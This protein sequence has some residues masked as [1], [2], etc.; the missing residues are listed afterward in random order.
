M[1][2]DLYVLRER[3]RIAAAQ[4]DL[5]TAIGAL[6]SAALQ[7]H[8]DED[9]YVAL[10]RP[11][12]DMLARRG[13]A[14][15][16]LTVLSYLASVDASAWK[17]AHALLPLVPPVDRA[18]ALAAQGRVSEAARE[19]ES[20][21]LAAASAVLCERAEDWPL[22][23]ALWSRLAQATDRHDAY[24]GALV[25]FNLARCAARCEDAAQAREAMVACVRLLEEAA[26][27]FE[28]IGQR[29]RAFDC[30]EVLVQVGLESGAFEDVLEGFV[31]C[32][33]ILR[34]DHMD[35]F[36]LEYFAESIATAAARG[37]VNAAATLARE[38]ADYARSLG[39]APTA[40]AYTLRQAELWQA[41]AR[42]HSSRGSSPTIVENALLAAVL[43]FGEVG[44]HGRVEALYG[45]LA[46]LNLEPARREHYVRAAKRYVDIE[47]EPL[48]ISAITPRTRS[49]QFTEVWRA[50]VLEWERA[51]SAAEACADLM[52]DAMSPELTRRKAMLARLTALQVESMPDDASAEAQGARVRLAV[53]LAQLQSYAVLSALEKL[54][55]RPERRV[56][57]AVLGALQTLFFKRTFVTVRAALRDPDPSVAA[58]AARTLE[59]LFFPHAFDPLTR[60]IRESADPGVRGAALR[61]IARIDTQEAAEF[62]LG[63]LGHGAPDDRAATLAAL[64]KSS[65]TKF[66]KVA[67][68]ILGGPEG[69]LH[70]S[71]R[72]LL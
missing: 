17:R 24:V 7:T 3:A 1:L 57:L 54:F 12:E 69:P 58:Q 32:I 36:A 29:E 28:S 19:M 27:H 68:D 71:L 16:A 25:R 14:R 15:G 42:R 37:E 9:E 21:G 18:R 44:Q 55:A 40:D 4:G 60:V 11:L 51:G 2:D 8:L 59:A 38:G 31:N 64:E 45:E 56:K 46:Q 23:R 22:A 72:E 53:E 67:R 50:D 34:E 26:D 52:S 13:D 30:F 49:A 39:H 43:A 65:G 48:E 33:R 6:R 63:V 47:D 62:L 10:L 35:R 41:V 66:A 5:E 61:A 70:A 20:A